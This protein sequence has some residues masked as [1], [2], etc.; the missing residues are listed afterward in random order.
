MKIK[1]FL[2]LPCSL[3]GYFYRY[4]LSSREII[5]EIKEIS[6]NSSPEGIFFQKSRSLIRRQK[7]R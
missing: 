7:R 2:N 1:L 4:T 6:G 3:A 5:F